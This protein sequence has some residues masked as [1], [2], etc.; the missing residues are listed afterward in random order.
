MLKIFTRKD[1]R[2]DERHLGRDRF[3]SRLLFFFIETHSICPSGSTFPSPIFDEGHLG[4][5]RFS[6]AIL[7]QIFFLSLGIFLSL[8]WVHPDA[9][10]TIWLQKLVSISSSAIFFLWLCL[11]GSIRILAYFC[12]FWLLEP[13]NHLLCCLRFAAEC[14]PTDPPPPDWNHPTVWTSTPPPSPGTPLP[15]GLAWVCWDVYKNLGSPIP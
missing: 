7:G 14:K 1:F 8:A 6:I 12:Q 2:A 4:R 9:R 13:S 15:P 3:N 11:V 5:G 10:N